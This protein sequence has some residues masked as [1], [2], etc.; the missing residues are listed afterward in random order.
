MSENREKRC[1]MAVNY[2]DAR[3]AGKPEVVDTKSLIDFQE[4][5]LATCKLAKLN[6]VAGAEIPKRY[7][8]T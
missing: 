5:Q 1:K 7:L 2:G 6:F 4:M 3:Q 8:V